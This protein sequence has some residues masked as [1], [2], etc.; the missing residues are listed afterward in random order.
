MDINSYKSHSPFGAL[1]ETFSKSDPTAMG[2]TVHDTGGREPA[3]SGSGRR[4]VRDA[5]AEV[6]AWMAGRRNR[7]E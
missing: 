2:N 6:R 5:S 3:F 7:R 1:G 4:A